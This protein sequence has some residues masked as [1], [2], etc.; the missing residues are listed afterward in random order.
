MTSTNLDFDP[1]ETVRFVRMLMYLN[2]IGSDEEL[3]EKLGA[4]KETLKQNKKSKAK[5]VLD[6]LNQK[7]LLKLAAVF[8][9]SVETLK[10]A[11]PQDMIKIYQ[12]F[13]D[14]NTG[15]GVGNTVRIEGGQKNERFDQI[16][17]MDISDKEKAEL[18]SK[19]S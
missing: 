5:R 10:K 12:S 14:G 17:K 13:G 9:V 16:M 6:N 18:L 8:D 19:F 4:S 1:K 3:G 7:N 11:D 15:S 2:R